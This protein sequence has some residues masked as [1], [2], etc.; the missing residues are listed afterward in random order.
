MILFD[1][2]DVDQAILI[3]GGTLDRNQAVQR[4]MVFDED[5]NPLDLASKSWVQMTQS[6]YDALSPPDPAKWY[7]IVG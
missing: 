7:V 2:Q 6:A 5:E 1:S 3:A 4:V